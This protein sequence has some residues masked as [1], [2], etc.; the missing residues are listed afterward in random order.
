[1][2]QHAIRYLILPGWQGSGPDHWQTHWQKLLPN[3]TRVEQL[4]WLNPEPGAWVEQLEHSI[5]TSNGPCVIIAH[6]LGCITLSHWAAL[7]SNSQLVKVSGALLVAP[8]DVERPGCPAALQGFAPIRSERLPF[9]SLLIGSSNDA[10]ASAV[11]ARQL[12]AQWGSEYVQL[13]DAGHINPKAGFSRWESGF[14]YLYQLQ[15]QIER[16]QRQRA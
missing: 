16:Q 3:T 12:A 8:A 9:P 2:Y 6:S 15:R 10:A 4:D 7:A 11:R 13:E 5:A 14:A 1:M